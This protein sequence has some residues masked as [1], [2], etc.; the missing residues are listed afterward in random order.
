[1]HGILRLD[2]WQ[3]LQPMRTATFNADGHRVANTVLDDS[4]SNTLPTSS[5]TVASTNLGLIEATKYQHNC[6]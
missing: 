3:S 4:C 6:D 2:Q 1:M 5:D